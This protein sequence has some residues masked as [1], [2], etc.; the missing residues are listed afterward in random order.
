[1]LKVLGALHLLDRSLSAALQWQREDQIWESMLRSVSTPQHTL[2]L[3]KWLPLKLKGS[4][5]Q[6]L[7]ET[8]QAHESF[9]DFTPLSWKY[10]TLRR[11][12]SVQF[13]VV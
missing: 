7:S 2:L 11:T 3:L 9:T 5:A 13:C 4:G 1:M 6:W 12:G 10:L 8:H